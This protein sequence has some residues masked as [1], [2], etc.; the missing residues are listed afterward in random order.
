MFFQVK[1]KIKNNRARLHRKGQRSEEEIR[2]KVKFAH[3]QHSDTLL[4]RRKFDYFSPSSRQFTLAAVIRFIT[5]SKIWHNIEKKNI[6][7]LMLSIQHASEQSKH[8]ENLIFPIIFKLTGCKKNII[9]SKNGEKVFTMFFYAQ[10]FV[11]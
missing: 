2:G 5:K 7:N 9:L 1:L 11:V 10:N 6:Q 3:A 8:Q 4:R